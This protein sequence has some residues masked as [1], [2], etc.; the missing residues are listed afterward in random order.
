MQLVAVVQFWR[1]EWNTYQ[2]ELPAPP[3]QAGR[4]ERFKKRCEASLP[5]DGAVHHKGI[6][7]N[8]A[9]RPPR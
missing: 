8:V 6:F 1:Q 4:I 7:W 9:D 3:G 5:R 2:G